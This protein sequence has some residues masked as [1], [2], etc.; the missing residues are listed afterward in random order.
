MKQRITKRSTGIIQS[1]LCVGLLSIALTGYVSSSEVNPASFSLTLLHINDHH[2]RLDEE[3]TTLK[4]P[5]AAGVTK[6]VSL[7]MGGFAR[8]AAAI[9]EEASKSTNVIKLHA[10]D[11][12][13]GDLYFTQSEGEADAAVMNTVCFDAMTFGN[14]EF[15][16]GDAG[17]SKFIGFL[18]KDPQK[19]QTPLLSSNVSPAIHPLSQANSSLTQL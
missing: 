19:C 18:N 6:S 16:T 4:L 11:A 2:S 17:L 14:H 8:V 10:G 15:D 7:P 12:L 1:V 5:N 3:S 13:T 9:S